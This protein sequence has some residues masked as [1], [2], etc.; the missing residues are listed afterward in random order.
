MDLMVVLCLPIC[1]G[2][3]VEFFKVANSGAETD[4]LLRMINV[5]E[6]AGRCY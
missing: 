5:S 1:H 3:V 6:G 4:A 2:G